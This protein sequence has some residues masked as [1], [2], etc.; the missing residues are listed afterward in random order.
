LPQCSISTLAGVIRRNL[1]GPK[2]FRVSSSYN[3]SGFFVHDDK[4][5]VFRVRVHGFSAHY[6]MLRGGI[7]F[8]FDAIYEKHGCC[9]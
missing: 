8:L 3:S 1:Y 9:G 6:T 4:S 5:T 7:L 2:Y